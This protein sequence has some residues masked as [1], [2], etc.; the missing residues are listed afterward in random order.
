LLLGV[1]CSRGRCPSG[2]SSGG[3]S[4]RVRT[5]YAAAGEGDRLLTGGAFRGPL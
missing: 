1:G 4:A 5:D 2:S 3:G